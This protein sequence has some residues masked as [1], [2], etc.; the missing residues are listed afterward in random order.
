MSLLLNKDSFRGN[1]WFLAFNRRRTIKSRL[2]NNYIVQDINKL[3]FEF[4]IEY[5]VVEKYII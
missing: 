1:L 3:R 4:C 2:L 5:N